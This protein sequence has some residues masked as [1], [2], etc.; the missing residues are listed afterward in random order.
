MK[1]LYCLLLAAFV[2]CISS[3]TK[4]GTSTSSLNGTVWA[5]EGTRIESKN[6]SFT[7]C[8]AIEFVNN[9]T[10]KFYI[11]QKPDSKLLKDDPGSF[12]VRFPYMTGY[13][14]TGASTYTYVTDGNKI[15]VPLWGKIFTLINGKLIPDGGGAEF[16]RLK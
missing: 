16:S 13:Y 15:I 9:N 1:K 14:I 3:C 12:T 7:L 5:T 2:V 10:L 8:N 6:Y 4:T 11:I